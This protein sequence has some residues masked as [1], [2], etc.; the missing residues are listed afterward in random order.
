MISSASA[1]FPVTAQSRR[2]SVFASLSKNASKLSGTATASV[3]PTGD[4]A[5]SRTAWS[6]RR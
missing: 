3:P 4:S 2:K 6:I 1:A 5:T